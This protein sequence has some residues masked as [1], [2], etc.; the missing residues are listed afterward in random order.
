MQRHP[1]RLLQRY[2][3]KFKCDHSQAYSFDGACTK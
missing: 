1:S 2:A 3:F